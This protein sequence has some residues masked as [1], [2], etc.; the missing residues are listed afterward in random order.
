MSIA[1][2]KIIRA[3]SQLFFPEICYSCGS[4]LVSSDQLLCLR[5]LHQLPYTRFELMAANPVEKIFWG[6]I[7]IEHAA[8]LFYFTKGSVM[9]R[10]LYQL[11][12]RSRQEVGQY[13]GRLIGNALT[14]S[15]YFKDFDMIIPLPLFRKKELQRGFNQARL[16]CEGMN[17]ILKIP[18]CDKVI[19]R[20]E[21]T[22]T[23]TH[24][25]RIQR[26][27]NMQDRFELKNPALAENKHLLLVDD[28]IT[29]GATLE[30]CGLE[31]LK[32]SNSKLS[33]LTLAYSSSKN[34]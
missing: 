32:A 2:S 4:D 14:K 23:Q 20:I 18:V 12:Y 5:C 26:W 17:E 9:E 6:R 33:I 1:S 30:S 22:E 13:C 19:E 8:S 7:H 21:A 34:V 10:L 16:I 27:Q 25:N 28:V 24:K 15:K 3:F 29:T 31:L 11:K